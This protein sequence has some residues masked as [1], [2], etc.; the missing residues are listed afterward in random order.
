MRIR[1]FT[2]GKFLL[3]ALALAVL[4]LANAPAALAQ[5][6][7]TVFVEGNC[8]DFTPAPV[9][10][11]PGCGDYDGDNAIGTTEDGDGDNVYGTINGALTAIA[12]S[13]RVLVVTS[14]TFFDPLTVSL[15]TGHVQIEA[16]EGVEANIDPVR[17]GDP[18]GPGGPN[19]AR[20]ENIGMLLSGLAGSSLTLRNLTVRHWAIGV[21]ATGSVRLVVEHCRFNNNRDY[22]IQMLTLSR[23]TMN[24]SQI[25]H[26]GRRD[27]GTPSPGNGIQFD[28]QS[29]GYLSNSVVANSVGIGVFQN[30]DFNVVL[31]RMVL[32]D[33]A[34]GNDVDNPA[35]PGV[36]TTC[37]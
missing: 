1:I 31:C 20:Q 18:A 37:S 7:R 28:D 9:R 17:P 13:G 2:V 6:N 34:G 5:A 23:I 12:G 29:G 15:T 11:H 3:P 21:R 14:G 25:A 24:N 10:A 22:G 32:S 33:N 19:V 30:S 36:F 16:A 35:E 27:G 4:V 8:N 26:T